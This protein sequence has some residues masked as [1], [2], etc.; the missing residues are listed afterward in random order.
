[1][2]FFKLGNHFL[3]YPKELILSYRREMIDV[4]AY[5]YHIIVF[6][7]ELVSVYIFDVVNISIL[8]HF[9]VHFVR[10]CFWY[11]KRR[12]A[13]SDTAYLFDL[14]DYEWVIWSSKLFNIAYDSIF[15]VFRY[16]VVK[17]TSLLVCD[18]CIP[19]VLPY[20]ILPEFLVVDLL[21]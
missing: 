8:K 2:P 10:S 13:N 1:M 4:S 18:Y 12:F 11:S 7:C 19:L 17:M 20:F 16:Y 15:Q 14:W 6:Y 3:L 5:I 9:C 21:V